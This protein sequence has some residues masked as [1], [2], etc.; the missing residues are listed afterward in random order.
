MDKKQDEMRI[1]IKKK[2]EAL[3]P[4][5]REKV[6]NRLNRMLKIHRFQNRAIEPKQVDNPINK[7]S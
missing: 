6:V 3:S 7:T 2:L 4:E 1:E 5:V